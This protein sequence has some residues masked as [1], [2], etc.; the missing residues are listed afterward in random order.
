MKLLRWAQPA[1]PHSIENR[2]GKR[3]R[4]DTHQ[5][6]TARPRRQAMSLSSK[7]KPNFN[8]RARRNE[9]LR[10][11]RFTTSVEKVSLPN[12]SRYGAGEATGLP[13]SMM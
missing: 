5:C 3:F 2:A 11:D 1:L 13:F 4:I 9:V 7:T 10:R 8:S 12:S 6:R